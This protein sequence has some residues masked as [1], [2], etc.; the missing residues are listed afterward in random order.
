[1]AEAKRIADQLVRA[2]EGDTWTGRSIRE[3]VAGFTP[4]QAA[5]RPIPGANSA[6]E[7]VGH[8]GAWLATTRARVAGQPAEPTPEENFPA[9]TAVT[10]EAW[11]G[12]WRGVES[13]YRGLAREIEALPDERLEDRVPGRD[14]PVYHLL[15]GVIQHSLYH[16]GQLVVLAKL[17]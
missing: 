9:A 12:V 10:L 3:I 2:F 5:S 4:E 14:Y 1:M 13:E 15:H 17:G 7:I 16:A 11:Q 8:I 6:W